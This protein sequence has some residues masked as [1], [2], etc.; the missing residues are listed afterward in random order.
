M[1]SF[2]Y[3]SSQLLDEKKAAAVARS[4]AENAT[5]GAKRA[6]KTLSEKVRRPDK[7]RPALSFKSRRVSAGIRVEAVIGK[8]VV[9]SDVERR[10]GIRIP[11]EQDLPGRL[12]A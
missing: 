9:V 4:A 3:V 8:R 11:S 6:L 2:N 1:R 7:E 5:G 12:R 10:S